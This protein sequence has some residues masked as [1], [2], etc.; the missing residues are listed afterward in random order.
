[1]GG[2]GIFQMLCYIDSTKASLDSSY[3]FLRW[4]NPRLSTSGLDSVEFVS[5]WFVPKADIDMPFTTV[6]AQRIVGCTHSYY[7]HMPNFG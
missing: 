6:P 4:K 7:E 5:R 1:M 2:D 3:L